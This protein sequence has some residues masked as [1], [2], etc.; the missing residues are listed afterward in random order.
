MTSLGIFL[1]CLSAGAPGPFLPRSFVEMSKACLENIDM[2]KQML[3]G[4]RTHVI[5]GVQAL[6]S[7]EC[8][9]A[10]T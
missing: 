9:E 1:F 5:C 3:A 7:S 6:V 4:V 2:G 8:T 10:Q